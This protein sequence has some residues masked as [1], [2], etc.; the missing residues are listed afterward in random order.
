MWNEIYLV[1]FFEDAMS[2]KIKMLNLRNEIDSCKNKKW[3]LCK[4]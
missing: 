1:H 2:K 3:M 4:G